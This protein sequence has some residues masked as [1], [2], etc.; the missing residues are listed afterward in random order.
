[1]SI[2]STG[3][4][5]HPLSVFNNNIQKASET[6]SNNSIYLWTNS[7]YL[8]QDLPTKMYMNYLHF[9]RE[10]M[11]PHNSASTKQVKYNEVN[12]II[13]YIQLHICQL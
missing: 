10:E 11:R 3:Q 7:S 13:N 12:E 9:P 5:P 8:G 1:M 2:N 6:I 4:N